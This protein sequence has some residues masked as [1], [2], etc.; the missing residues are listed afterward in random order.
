MPEE[1]KAAP[2]PRTR[3]VSV[4]LPDFNVVSPW[5]GVVRWLTTVKFYDVSNMEGNI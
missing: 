4:L 3:M 5:L 1:T 2:A